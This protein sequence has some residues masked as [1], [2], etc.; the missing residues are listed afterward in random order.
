[1]SA[2]SDSGVK[3][4]RPTPAD[5]KQTISDVTLLAKKRAVSLLDKCLNNHHLNSTEQRDLILDISTA[6]ALT[7]ANSEVNSEDTDITLDIPEPEKQ[8]SSSRITTVPKEQPLKKGDDHNE[9]CEVCE[10]GGDLLCCDSCTL[11]FHLKCIRPKIMTIPKGKWSCAHCVSDG[12]GTGDAFKAKNALI[13]MGRLSRGLESEDESDEGGIVHTNSISGDISVIRSGKRFIV[14]EIYN[15]QINELGRYDSLDDA[16]GSIKPV[17][18]KASVISLLQDENEV[19]QPMPTPMQEEDDLWCTHCMDDPA[20][21]ICAF[22]G[23]RTCFGK[24][25]SEYLL[26][27]DYCDQESHTYCL[28]PQLTVIP[29]DAW[30]CGSCINLGLTKVEVDIPVLIEEPL[31][32]VEELEE[33][34]EIEEESV[35]EDSVDSIMEDSV[36]VKRV[37]GRPGRPK[38]IHIGNSDDYIPMVRVPKVTGRGRGRPPG[39]AKVPGP[40]DLPVPVRSVKVY[41]GSHKKYDGNSSKGF[42]QGSLPLNSPHPPQIVGGGVQAVLGIL[43]KNEGKR[44][45]W[46]SEKLLLSQMREWSPIEDLQ[47]VHKA[48]IIHKEI[49][50]NKIRVLDSNFTEPLCALKNV[51]DNELLIKDLIIDS[52]LSAEGI[53]H[54]IQM[55]RD[56]EILGDFCI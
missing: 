12:V 18:R 21:V 44:L 30:Y 49:M 43:E 55:G 1:M 5:Y 45:F 51:G 3:R 29:E 56:L 36:P 2:I 17:Y 23:C 32:V 38:K 47:I 40:N 41:N 54:A 14:R 52:T 8:R 53:L 31:I 11:V 20:V 42:G 34:V 9:E 39:T 35:E 10:K 6:F 15:T 33:E 26:L 22:C 25:N 7:L 50:L 19:L 4:Q 13:M 48:L 24:H 46:P 27:C 16:L 28:T 37:K